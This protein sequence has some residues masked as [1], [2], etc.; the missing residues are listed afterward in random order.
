VSWRHWAIAFIVLIAGA[1]CDSEIETDEGSTASPNEHEDALLSMVNDNH[2]DDWQ[3]TWDE[4]LIALE[5][6]FGPSDDKIITAM[7]PL[8]LGGGADVLTFKEHTDGIAYVTAGLI[9]DGGQEK[10]ELGEYELVMCVRDE[11]EW[12]PSLLSRLAPYTF[13]AAVNPGDTMDI[14]TAMPKNSTIAALLFVSYRKFK[15]SETDAGALLAMGITEAELTYCREHGCEDVLSKLK[16]TGIFPFT[17]PRRKS[18]I[19]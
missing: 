19:Q 15:V 14:A 8:Y 3:Q 16:N 17:E 6:E 5:H 4:R 13:D 18:V 7:P 2:D 11:N 1:G 10:T 12:A 9:G